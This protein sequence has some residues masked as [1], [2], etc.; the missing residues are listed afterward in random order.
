MLYQRGDFRGARKVFENLLN[1]R[2]AE[3]D[4]RGIALAKT[5]LADALC[6][7]SETDRAAGLYEQ[8]LDNLAQ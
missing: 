3:G 2:Q 5:N 7:Q 8:A 1:I 4:K 6:V